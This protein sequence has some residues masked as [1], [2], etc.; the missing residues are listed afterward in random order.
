MN[1]INK[2]A[3][4][5]KDSPSGKKLNSISRE[6]LNFRRRPFLCT[7]LYR[8]LMQ[9]SNFG[10]T[11]DQLSFEFFYKIFTKDASLL[12]LYHGAKKSKMTKNSNQ[13][14]GGGGGGSC[15]KN[16]LSKTSIHFLSHDFQIIAITS[17]PHRQ[18]QSGMCTSA[19]FRWCSKSL[20]AW[21]PRLK[22]AFAFR[23]QFTLASVHARQAGKRRSSRS[24]NPVPALHKE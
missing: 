23:K 16:D 22:A 24:A 19:S 12:V 15:L 14:L 2:C 8:N 1:M 10:G 18:Q 6:R 20:K 3:K 13:S 5:H 17:P 9:A 7:T 21:W 11:F 4:F